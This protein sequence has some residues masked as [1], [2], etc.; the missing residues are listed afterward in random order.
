MRVTIIGVWSLI[1]IY[2]SLLGDYAF[3]SVGLACIESSVTA[4]SLVEAARFLSVYLHKQTL[5]TVAQTFRMS[6]RY[7]D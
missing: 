5:I 1:C 2:L 6:E 3:E 4:N 7:A